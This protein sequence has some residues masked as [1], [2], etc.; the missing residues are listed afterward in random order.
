MSCLT[1]FSCRSFASRIF[2]TAFQ[3]RFGFQ[4]QTHLKSLNLR[5]RMGCHLLNLVE[6]AQVLKAAPCGAKEVASDCNSWLRT[7]WR[8]RYCR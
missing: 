3:M 2:V 7:D 5:L 6:A 1:G 4:F 8:T